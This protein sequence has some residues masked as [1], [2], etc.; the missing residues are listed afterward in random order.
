MTT[1]ASP[2]ASKRLEVMGTL[3][4][5]LRPAQRHLL[6]LA[7]ADMEIYG[8]MAAPRILQRGRFVVGAEKRIETLQLAD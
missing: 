7:G 1:E 5:F 8:V 6:S 3:G 4:V 2:R